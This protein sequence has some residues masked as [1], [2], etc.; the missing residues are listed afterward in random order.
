MPPTTA[1]VA[2][3]RRFVWVSPLLVVVAVM[4]V[5]AVVSGRPVPGAEASAL[6]RQVLSAPLA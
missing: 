2:V 4:G 6:V 3:P 5:P 1:P